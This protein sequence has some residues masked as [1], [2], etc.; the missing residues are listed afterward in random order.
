[1]KAL[2]VVVLV[3]LSVFGFSCSSK[4]AKLKFK[5]ANA[6][7]AY[8]YGEVDGPAKQ[9]KNTYPAATPETSEKANA[10]RALVESELV[11]AKK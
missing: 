11:S 5:D 4:Y 6:S 3:S 8:I 7:S 1:M 2:K 9:L 10:F